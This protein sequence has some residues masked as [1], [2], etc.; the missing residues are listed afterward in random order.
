[1]ATSN[2]V[3]TILMM[4]IL[5]AL[6]VS[7]CAVT[8]PT[9][10]DWKFEDSFS[11]REGGWPTG[12]NRRGDE[13]GYI[14]GKYHI[15]IKVKAGQVAAG[16]ITW[17][18]VYRYRVHPLIHALTVEADAVQQTGSLETLYGVVCGT[19][20][21]VLY[22]FLINLDGYYFIV[23][24]D[25]RPF[26]RGAELLQSGRTN[27][28]IHGISEVNHIRAKCMGGTHEIR[29]T[30]SVNGQKVADARR[31]GGGTFNPVGFV[32]TTLNAIANSTRAFAVKGVQ[33]SS[34]SLMDQ[35]GEMVRGRLAEIG[36]TK[37][38]PGSPT[39]SEAEVFFDNFVAHVMERE[40]TDND[41]E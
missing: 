40:L 30:L 11:N 8:V 32:V 16:Q 28:I 25:A 17:I 22:F 1:M 31:N 10:S 23:R 26:F 20:P 5:S 21:G 14:D 24:D 33:P 19:S 18:P 9:T 36:V 29:L 27:V 39:D 3:Q 13:W 2:K 37:E 7:G 38:M 41:I 34:K 15:L 6:L 35:I 4:S 12:S